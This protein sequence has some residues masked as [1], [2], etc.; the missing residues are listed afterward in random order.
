M[1]ESDIQKL[2]PG[3]IV[4]LFQLDATNNG[5]G[6]LYWHNGVN[7]LGDDVV[8]D[9]IS[10]SRF[11]VMASGFAKTSQGTIP[12][13]KIQVANVSGLFGAVIREYDQFLGATL[14]RIRTFVKYLDAVNFEGGVN[15]NADPTVML[16]PDIWSVDRKASENGI[17]IEF[18]LAAST[19]L[20]GVQIPRRQMIQNV[21][22]WKYRGAECSYAGPPVATIT[23]A[24]TSDPAQDK[25]GKRLHSCELRF[26]GQLPFGSFIG[27]NV[28]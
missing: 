16:T 8:F 20:T 3:A 18:E 1:I 7:E 21:C 24:P 19:D 13:P 14:T 2:E 23:D 10:Y 6:I 25:C 12:R 28:Q 27:L 11:P 4:E 22:V 9:G 15:P 17:F 5:A 26:A